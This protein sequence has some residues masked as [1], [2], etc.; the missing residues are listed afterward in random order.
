MRVLEYMDNLL[1]IRFHL[2]QPDTAVSSLRN[3]CRLLVGETRW[4]GAYLL[5]R[6]QPFNPGH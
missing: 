2:F 4:Y 1:I 5:P 3:L 6:R